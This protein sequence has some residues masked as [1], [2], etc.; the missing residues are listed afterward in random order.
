MDITPAQTALA[1]TG[2]YAGAVDNIMGPGTM[3]G[4]MMAAAGVH[5]PTKVMTAIAS[6]LAGVMAMAELTTPLRLCHFLA[7]A[8]EE[9]AGWTS[10]V[11]EGGPT[12]FAQY[13][14]RFGNDEPGD[15][16][17]YRGR[18]PL[19]L[20]FRSNYEQFGELIS[21]DLL[22]SPDLLLMDMNRSAQA[23]AAFWTQRQANRWADVDNIT[24]VTKLINGGL[25][26]LA[27][28]QAALVR[29]KALWGL[30]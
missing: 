11:E 10:L 23:A 18:G 25:N 26:G 2:F 12:Y 3:T 24:E 20:T 22:N 6:A 5:T 28:R 16:Y 19:M 7:Q 1:S 30:S 13:D 21:A 15:G 9:T 29:L 14:G 4:L 17:K 8:T 27:S